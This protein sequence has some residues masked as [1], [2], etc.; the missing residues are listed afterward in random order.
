VEAGKNNEYREYRKPS[1]CGLG[2]AT[3]AG[4]LHKIISNTSKSKNRFPPI[5][6]NQ[7]AAS[8]RKWGRLRFHS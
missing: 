4:L 7:V 6:E 1:A 3:S 8:L 2:P 5:G